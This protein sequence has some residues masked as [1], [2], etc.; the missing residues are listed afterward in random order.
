MLSFSSLPSQLHFRAIAL[1]STFALVLAIIPSHAE[2]ISEGTFKSREGGVIEAMGTFEVQQTSG[3]F[4]LMIQSNFK[5]S[6]GPDLFFVFSPFDSAQLTGK[7]PKT[8]A[9]KVEPGLKSI[10]GAQTYDLP[11]D[12]DLTKYSSL[13]VHCWQYDHL[14]ATAAIKKIAVTSLLPLRNGERVSPNK[15]GKTFTFVNRD[16]MVFK[17]ESVTRGFKIDILGQRHY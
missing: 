2:K 12:F 4:T 8:S 13:L 17:G 7:S 1:I 6:D 14:F 11:N 9:L 16:G 3:K 10:T 15:S 5:V